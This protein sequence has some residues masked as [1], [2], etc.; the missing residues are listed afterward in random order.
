MA[1]HR[2][3]V[4]ASGEPPS[5]GG[6]GGS[7]FERLVHECRNGYLNAE[8][9]AVVCNYP[10][11]KVAQR[12]RRLGVQ[13]EYFVHSK[14]DPAANE[15]QYVS[16]VEK[17]QPDL[18]ILAGWLKLFTGLDQ[19]T[20]PVL[21][22]HPGHTKLHGCLHGAGVHRAVMQDF[23][24]S[25]VTE[26]FVSIHYVTAKYDDG[27]VIFQFPVRIHPDDTTET[28]AERVLEVEHSYYWRVIK[29]VL[30]GF[31]TWDCNPAHSPVFPETYAYRP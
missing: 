22:I 17:Y 31:I 16:L 7:S 21:N 13:F 20:V 23:A 12:A 6:G 11:N 1:K 2:L 27:P 9:V 30:E 8:V 5:K 10:D 29:L 26:T 24:A 14:D 18:V 25:L 19:I 28:L 15:R 4:F 3:L